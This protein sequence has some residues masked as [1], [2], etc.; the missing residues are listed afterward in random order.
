MSVVHSKANGQQIFGNLRHHQL[1]LISC[2]CPGALRG[3]NTGVATGSLP[4]E[5]ATLPSWS[6]RSAS[7]V[8]I[9]NLLAFPLLIRLNNNISNV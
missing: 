4:K 3:N 9:Y 7:N 2:S 6:I 8:S 1:L 5:N